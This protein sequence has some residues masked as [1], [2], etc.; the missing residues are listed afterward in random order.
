MT[1]GTQLATSL[2]IIGVSGGKSW[3]PS[4]MGVHLWL[5]RKPTHMIDMCEWIV[6]GWEVN[7]KG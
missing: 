7:I 3:G 1:G 4:P 2:L 5:G 6:G